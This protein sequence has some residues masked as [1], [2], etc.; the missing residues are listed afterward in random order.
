MDRTPR[1]SD[2][3]RLEEHIDKLQAELEKHRWIPVSE[4]LPETDELAICVIKHFHT[5]GI[6]VTALFK[7]DEDDTLW[8]TTDDNSELAGEWNVTHWMPINLP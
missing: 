3:P 7:V 1:P 4:R 6:K 5:Q 8:R 2:I